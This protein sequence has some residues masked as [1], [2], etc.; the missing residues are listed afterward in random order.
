MKVVVTSKGKQQTFDVEV[1]LSATG[2]RAGHRELRT[3]RNEGRDRARLRPGRSAS[4]APAE[5]NVYAIGDIVPTPALAHCASA[6]G[7][8]A[9]EHMAGLEVRPINY[10][11]VP[12]C[13]LHRSGSGLASA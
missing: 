10:D 5:P 11:H 7:I 3:G 8:L 1:V 6:E 2:R 9:V 12:N 4:C 13:H